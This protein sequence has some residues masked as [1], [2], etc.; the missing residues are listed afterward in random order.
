[1]SKKSISVGMAL[2]A[3]GAAEGLE[4]GVSIFAHREL[5]HGAL[6]TTRGMSLYCRFRLWTT[7]GQKPR[8][9]V[10]VHRKHHRFSDQPGDPHSP[11]QE[12]VGGRDG[13]RRVKWGT[14]LLYRKAVKDPNLVPT[15]A[16]ELASPD[17][18][19][20]KIF[21]KGLIGVAVVQS[22]GFMAILRGMGFR[23]RD[24]ITGTAAATL[25][26]LAVAVR[27]GGDV[28]AKSHDSKTQDPETHDYSSN[29]GE[30]VPGWRGKIIRAKAA[31]TTAGEG[32]GHRRH[33]LEAYSA[34]FSEGW[35]DPAGMLVKTYAR[36]GWLTINHVSDAADPQRSLPRAT[37][38][39][40]SRIQAMTPPHILSEA[41]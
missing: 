5:T 15:Y 30:G 36:L 40:L 11:I 34:V 31:V 17:M 27:A 12:S 32:S 23:G 16:P 20:R 19:D 14:A 39:D 4:K 37:G 26:S 10:A 21:D 6:K 29:Q 13:Y 2:G 41:A 28:N 38:E 1:M 25:T 9:W 24:L 18:L 35:L 8:Q 22:L 3:T 33:H 7:T